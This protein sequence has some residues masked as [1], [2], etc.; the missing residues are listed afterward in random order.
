LN[1]GLKNSVAL[2]AGGFMRFIV[3]VWRVTKW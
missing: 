1:L 3:W 2:V